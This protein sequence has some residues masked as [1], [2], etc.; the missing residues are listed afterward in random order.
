MISTGS[1]DAQEQHFVPRLSAELAA[2][3][4]ARDSARQAFVEHTNNPGSTAPLCD[5]ERAELLR[6]RADNAAKHVDLLKV[7]D[8]NNQL[9]GALA[10]Q[11]SLL[12]G[13][14]V[15]HEQTRRR[16]KGTLVV[17]GRGDT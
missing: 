2:G 12:K 1:A 5:D 17:K 8:Q 16:R 13:M 14:K 9:R 15:A 11:R 6:L 10:D 3:L 4:S 7:T